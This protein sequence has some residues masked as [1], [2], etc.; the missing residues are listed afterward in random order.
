MNKDRRDR[1]HKLGD[2]LNEL[3]DAIEEIAEEEREVIENINENFVDA[4][5]DAEAVLEDVGSTVET[6]RDEANHLLEV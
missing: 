6:L 2:S 1:L 5:A 3:A 4:I